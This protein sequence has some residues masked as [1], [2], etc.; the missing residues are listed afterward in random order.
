MKEIFCVKKEE[1]RNVAVTIVFLFL[2]NLL[3]VFRYVLLLF[4]Y[5]GEA[6]GKFLAK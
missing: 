1:L 4:E 6:Y 5:G 2:L 3:Y